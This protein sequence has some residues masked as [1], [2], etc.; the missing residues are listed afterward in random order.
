MPSAAAPSSDPLRQPWLHELAVVVAGNATLLSAPDGDLDPRADGAQADGA[1]AQGLLVDDRRVLA[2]LRLEVGGEPAS[3]VASRVVGS[4]AGFLGAARGLGD[5][6]PDPTVE[7][8][9]RREL[10]GGL[11]ERVTVRSRASVPVE[12]DVVWLAGADGLD[13]AQVKAGE[14]VGA[15]LPAQVEAD[16]VSWQDDWHATR[17]RQDP[18]PD[19]VELRGDG[20]TAL[21]T[22]VSVPAGGEVTL[23]LRAEVTRRRAS[24]FDADA[25]ASLVDWSSAALEHVADRRVAPLVAASLADLRHLLL[26]DPEG[27]DVFAGAGTPWYLT[28]FG[29]DSL[30]AARMVL[31]FGTDLAAGTLRAL[32]RRQGRRTDPATGEAQGKI[33]HE[34][35]RHVYR[36]EVSGM[37]LPQ[38]YYGTV[39]ATA[40]WV[41]LLVDAWRWGLDEAVVRDLLEPLHAALGWLTG[42]GRDTDGLVR[43]LDETGTGLANQG[44]K[45]SGDSVRRRDG[46]LAPGPIALVE[47]QAY[48]VEALRGAAGLLRALGEPGAEDAEK[49]AVELEDAVRQRF[50]VTTDA[51]R[52][53]ALAVDGEGRAVDGLASN[54]GHVLGTGALDDAESAAV[55]ATLTGEELLDGF[56]VRTLGRG[57]GGFNPIGYHTGSIWTHDTAVCAWNLARAGFADEAGRVAV[58]LVASGESFGRRWPEL[59]SGVPF[60][61]APTPYPAACRPQAW[62]A[63]SAAVLASVALGVEADVP[64]GELRLRPSR[65]F[66][67]VTVRGLR[68]G[69][70]SVTVRTGADGSV[71]EV[72][73]LPEGVRVVVR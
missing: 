62:S 38:V 55:A 43:Y 49:H 68:V 2:V 35:R 31:P 9:R 3:P 58:T 21:T 53:L 10:D 72:T 1:R 59:Y 56:G 46:S 51:G 12:T 67:P 25:G 26:R 11:V 63:A 44:W 37:V 40:L 52:H 27:G 32:A 24:A 39:D 30:W 22:R 66:G 18:A 5:L 8:E 48:A 70:A 45:D 41:S 16:G 36:D 60:G 17:L 33:P 19:A 28:L 64:A 69:G 47:A 14:P 34:L 13:L 54:M 71:E 7:V 20:V 50:W 42:P 23:V 15:L 6:G 29:R 57:N 65:T 61:D 73:G 4:G